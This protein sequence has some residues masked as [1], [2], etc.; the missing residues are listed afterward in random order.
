MLVHIFAR[1][2]NMDKLTEYSRLIDDF[3]WHGKGDIFKIAKLA[4]ELGRNYTEDIAN[5]KLQAIQSQKR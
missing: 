5:R 3:A 4:K 2:E 1:G